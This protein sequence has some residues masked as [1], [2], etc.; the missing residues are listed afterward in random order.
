MSLAQGIADAKALRLDGPWCIL[1]VERWS[2]RSEGRG[3][4][5]EEA[6]VGMCG[7]STHRTRMRFSTLYWTEL[8]RGEGTCPTFCPQKF[9]VAA[10]SLGPAD[11]LIR[12]WL[13]Y[14]APNTQLLPVVN[15]C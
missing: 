7:T 10:A 15:V 8:Q 13:Q 11:D 5:G 14:E 3:E 12:P 2:V 1:R 4:K 9:L 6:D